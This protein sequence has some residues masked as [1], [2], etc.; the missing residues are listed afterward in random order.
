MRK[1]TVVTLDTEDKIRE[2]GIEIP[3]IPCRIWLAAL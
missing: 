3:A 1:L 2:G